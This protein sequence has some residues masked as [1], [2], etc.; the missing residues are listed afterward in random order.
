[1]LADT[2]VPGLVLAQAIGRVG[3]VI[4]AHNGGATTTV[5]W[6][7]VDTDPH[8]SIPRDLLGVPTHPDPLYDL[9][10]NLVI[11]ALL[12]CWRTRARPDGARFLVYVTLYAVGRFALTVVRQERVWFWGSPEAQVIALLTLA[13]AALLPIRLTWGRA[14]DR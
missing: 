5:P 4:N 1:M 9:A 11:F 10:L 12:W 13:G 8:A 14:G 3:C 2:V 7:F 6:A